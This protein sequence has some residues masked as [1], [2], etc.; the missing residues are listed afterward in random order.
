MELGSL[1]AAINLYTKMA[2]AAYATEYDSINMLT[3]H[4]LELVRKI[5]VV[6]KPVEEITKLISTDAASV[7]I[8]LLRALEKPLTKHHDDSGIQTM[9]FKILSLLK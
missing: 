5:I 4:Q 3:T 7:L 1:H 2:L 9:K 6:L 8:P